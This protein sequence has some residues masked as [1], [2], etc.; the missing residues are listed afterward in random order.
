MKNDLG[1]PLP[2]FDAAAVTQSLLERYYSLDIEPW[3]SSLAE[4]A[5]WIGPGNLFVFGEDAIRK[6]FRQ[7]YMP[8][9]HLTD[10]EFTEIFRSE[11]LST[12][13]GQFNAVSDAEAE[14]IAAA[15]QRITFQY[16]LIKNEWKIIHM[17]V[18]NE[19]SELVD[20]EVYPVKM[21][22]ETYRYMQRMLAKKFMDSQKLVLEEDA[23]T[24]ILSPNEI[25]CIEAMKNQCL[26]HCLDKTVVSSKSISMLEKILPGNFYRAHRSYLVNC[27][28]VV[29]IARY[30][31]ELQGGMVIPLPEKR[32][33]A[34]REGI[35]ALLRDTVSPDAE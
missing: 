11:T 26:L 28:S 24:Y 12:V 18:S 32:Y 31:L 35:K 7:I 13:V 15:H 10:M 33:T 34:I 22:Q 20:D 25:V 9:I 16:Q 21:S 17:H 8:V 5:M 29:K 6:L 30:R 1:T 23:D 2:D 19:Y 3:L 4:N 14:K 27:N